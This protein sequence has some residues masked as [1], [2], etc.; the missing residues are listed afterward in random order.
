MTGSPGLSRK[1]QN[2]RNS[3]LSSKYSLIGLEGSMF[4][5]SITRTPFESDSY[6]EYPSH[7]AILPGRKSDPSVVFCVEDFFIKIFV[8]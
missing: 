2:Q 8:W 1:K 5:M 3:C 7:I 4:L 6:L